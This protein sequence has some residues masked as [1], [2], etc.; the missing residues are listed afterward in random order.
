MTP[1]ASPRA[2]SRAASRATSRATSRAA[3]L[4]ALLALLVA[5]VLG[6]SG[7]GGSSSRNSPAS[8]KPAGMA[9][10]AE[11]SLPAEARDVIKRIENGGG[12]QYRQDG[13]TFQNHERQLPAEP[14]GY[15][16]EYTVATP[17]AV[18][19]GARRLV[20]GKNGELYYTQDHYKSFLRVVR[21]GAT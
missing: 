1:S 20:L 16:R 6:L 5:A 9:T 8:L 3:P 17:G 14:G 4:A 13:V 15:Y 10:V 18:D 7:C 2:A 19:R 12:F 21:G 11:T